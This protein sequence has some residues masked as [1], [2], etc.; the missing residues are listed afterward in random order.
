MPTQAEINNTEFQR[1]KICDDCNRKP[2]IICHYRNKLW[3]C[4]DCFKKRCGSGKNN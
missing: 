1:T 3:L 4:A 2:I